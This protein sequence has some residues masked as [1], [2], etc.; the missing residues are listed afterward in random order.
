MNILYYS[1]HCPHSNNILKKIS[2]SLVKDDFCYIS[3]DNRFLKNEKFFVTLRNGE[4]F[5]I[6]TSVDKV[7]ALMLKG[8][9]NRVIFGNE[10]FNFIDMKEK[11]KNISNDIFE[12]S[13]FSL[14]S[15]NDNV[16]SD[17]YSFLDIPNE[18]FNAASGNSGMLQPFNYN[19]A[20]IDYDS[21]MNTPP[22]EYVPD[23]ISTDENLL[24]KLVET[25]NKDL[26][27]QQPRI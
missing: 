13:P 10:I 6:D 23:K 1:S 26:P 27:V 3:L 22:D 8:Y 18:E 25:R 16:V 4:E 2:K 21:Y 19:Y 17:N 14:S 5:E 12:P 24:E 9:G 11:E 20:S 15:S 7:P